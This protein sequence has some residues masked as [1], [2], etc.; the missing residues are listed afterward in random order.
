[1]KLKFVAPCGDTT[2]TD[3]QESPTPSFLLTHDDTNKAG[4]FAPCNFEQ[5]A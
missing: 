1:M 5:M 2:K 4:T 3:F